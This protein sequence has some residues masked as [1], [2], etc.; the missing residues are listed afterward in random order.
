[1]YKNTLYFVPT[2]G[3]KDIITL[4][5]SVRKD[6]TRDGHLGPSVSYLMLPERDIFLAH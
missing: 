2:N 6:L 1:M 3:R 4:F 5:D